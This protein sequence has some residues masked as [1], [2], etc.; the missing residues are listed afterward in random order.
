MCCGS[1]RHSAYLVFC[2]FCKKCFWLQKKAGYVFLSQVVGDHCLLKYI[3]TGHIPPSENHLCFSL[4]A[5]LSHIL[6][7]KRQVFCILDVLHCILEV[8]QYVDRLQKTIC[9]YRGRLSLPQ[10]WF[11]CCIIWIPLQQIKYFSK[12]YQLSFSNH[13]AFANTSSDFLFY[14][15]HVIWNTKYYFLGVFIWSMFFSY[16]IMFPCTHLLYVK[17]IKLSY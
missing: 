13:L 14:F 3:K 15:E 7:S 2:F 11:Y 4:F 5:L 9:L 1:I 17:I 6:V 8:L 10:K 16:K 12:F